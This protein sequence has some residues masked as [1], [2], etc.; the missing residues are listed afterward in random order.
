MKAFFKT[1]IKMLALSTIAANTSNEW[2]PTN[3]DH[4]VQSNSEGV[5]TAQ[6]FN[7]FQSPIDSTPDDRFNPWK[8]YQP[9]YN[10]TND[11]LKFVYYSLSYIQGL[12]LMAM[13]LT[14][15]A[16]KHKSL[17]LTKKPITM[18]G[19]GEQ[20]NKSDALDSTAESNTTAEKNAGFIR[21]K[22]SKVLDVFTHNSNQL[23]PMGVNR[24]G[25]RISED[26]PSQNGWYNNASS[27]HTF[28]QDSFYQEQPS[29]T[30]SF[31]NRHKRRNLDSDFGDNVEPLHKKVRGPEIKAKRTRT[32]TSDTT[33][34]ET[35]QER[36]TKRAYFG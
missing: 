29:T 34:N 7:R 21:R 25:L 31:L 13:T 12:K 11:A 3:S 8:Q 2:N 9:Y 27:S 35:V 30:F 16:A 4:S 24:D 15:L 32:F 17:F 23:N 10:A 19:N 20:V 26:M 14:F 6:D 5:A 1:L 33:L 28:E 36:S 18:N 22:V